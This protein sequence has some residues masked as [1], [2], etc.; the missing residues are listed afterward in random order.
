MDGTIW[1]PFE[2]DAIFYVATHQV[3]NGV[4]MDFPVST[5]FRNPINYI[6]QCISI[7]CHYLRLSEK[8]DSCNS[9][10]S[11]IYIKWNSFAITLSL[12]DNEFFLFV[13]RNER[14]ILTRSK[15]PDSNKTLRLALQK[16]LYLP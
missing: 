5:N 1:K 3:P 11:L 9:R 14:V 16:E 6:N 8:L 4:C 10:N 13:I 7:A 12:N 2:A 15:Y